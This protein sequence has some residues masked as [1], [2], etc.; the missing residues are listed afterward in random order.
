[1]NP[2]GL[3]ATWS[4]PAR[5]RRNAATACNATVARLSRSGTTSRPPGTSWSYQA[6]GTTSVLTVTITPS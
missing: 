2:P 1:M 4:N 6:R 3:T 5:T